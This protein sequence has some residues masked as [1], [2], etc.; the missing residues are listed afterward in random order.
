[1]VLTFSALAYGDTNN[2]IK[3]TTDK[4]AGEGKRVVRVGWYASEGVHAVDKNGVPSGFDYEYLQAISQY[5]HWK[6]IYVKGSWEE[7]FQWLKEGKIDLLGVVNKT[8]ERE[9]IFDFSNSPIG[10]EFCC[11][12]VPQTNSKL[13]YEDYDAFN[14]MTIAIEKGAYQGQALKTYAA[15]KGFTYKPLYCDT[16]DEASQMVSRGKADALLASNTDIIKGHKT[17]DQFSPVMFYYATTKGNKELLSE[18]NAGIND[19]FTYFPNFN[20]YMYGKFY[21]SKPSSD[22]VFSEEEEEYIK[23]APTIKILVDPIWYPIEYYDGKEYKGIVPDVIR[24]IQKQSGLDI[25]FINSGNSINA[26]EEMK[27][28]KE[29]LI[30]S[31]SYN[32]HWAN[33]NHVNITQPF[34][35]SVIVMVSANKKTE[36]KKV[37][38]VK[39]DYI[40]EMI[41]ASQTDIT[42]VLY[43]TTLECIDAVKSGE[44]DCTYMNN[45]EAEYYM[46]MAKYKDLAFHTTERYT[47]DLSIG[48]S[49]YSDPR[50]FSIISKCVQAIPDTEIQ[51]II[52]ENSYHST[53]ITLK[54]FVEYNP[55]PVAIISIVTILLVMIACYVVLRSKT[56][57][58]QR[59]AIENRRYNQIAEISNEHIYEYNYLT[60]TLT[61]N[62]KPDYFYDG[63]TVIP[64]YSKLIRNQNLSS[65]ENTLYGCF[66]DK[67]DN[68]KEVYMMFSVAEKHWYEV[69]TKII[70]DNAERPIYAIGKVKDIQASHEEKLALAEQAKR[71]SLT[72]LYNAKAYRDIVDTK[73]QA[74]SILIAIDVDNFKSVND[75]YGHFSGDLVLTEISRILKD[76]FGSL[77]YIGRLGGDEFSVFL[78]EPMDISMLHKICSDLIRESHAIALTDKDQVIHPITI[79]LGVCMTRK[80]E[81]FITMYK[82]ADKELYQVKQDGRNGYKIIQL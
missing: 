68:I 56:A 27:K 10:T 77:G 5:T 28:D 35:K 29:N 17:I 64:D 33:K 50:L 26:L 4:Y 30:T 39:L 55:I 31:I 20:N 69:T 21:G 48:V 15:E 58:A 19:L 79:S 63:N 42:P 76:A 43:N 65:F 80:I 7:C 40:N 11:L 45:Y 72:W 66:T 82:V 49:E 47:Q 24:L 71:D 8:P 73:K 18:L 2:L 22:A 46:T 78:P 37:A 36:K 59:I 70:T 38:L 25:E 6:Y 34:I 12:F 54:N 16:L 1:M 61:F 44:A 53:P 57:T 75:K 14:G 67:K 13:K 51:N 3:D 60:D 23:S 74:G 52:Y 9:A 41:C 32:Y 62:K 81:D